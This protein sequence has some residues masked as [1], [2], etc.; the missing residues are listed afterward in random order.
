MNPTDQPFINPEIIWRADFADTLVLFHPHLG[1]AI[2]VAGFARDLWHA[3]DGTRPLETIARELATQYAQPPDTVLDDTLAFTQELYR[4]MFVLT[5]PLAP[6]PEHI[7]RPPHYKL[8]ADDATPPPAPVHD[9]AFGLTLA[10]G[11]QFVLRAHDEHAARVVTFFAESA[12]L[13]QTSKVLKTFEVLVATR[14]FD[15][16]DKIVCKVQPPHILRRG[17]RRRETEGRIG[18]AY[19]PLP[20]NQW[21]WLQL[22]QLAACIGNQIQKRGG[23]LL[24]SAL[25]ARPDLEGLEDLPGLSGV[26]LTAHSG[27]GKSTASKRLPAPWVALCDDTTLI[28]RDNAGAYWAH[29]TP[30]WSHIFYDEQIRTWDT[31]SAVPLRAI[32]LLRQGEQDRVTPLN[33]A[34][35]LGFL[36][37]RAQEPTQ[38]WREN[39]SLR[40]LSAFNREQFDNL[41]DLVRAVPC[42]LLDARLD[43][44]FWREMARVLE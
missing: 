3:L 22:L 36:L 44:E 8:P 7:E 24:H 28:V 31:Q 23:V 4:R 37:E 11:T 34:H 41:C 20:D 10:D 27:V 33:P 43:G 21:L 1:Q 18:F 38:Y 19:E 39:F 15:A 35:A 17:L 9:V 14:P 26:L 42:Y 29:P 16:P 6:A 40:E 32:F 13:A 12:Q 25:A 30:T 2:P 5:E